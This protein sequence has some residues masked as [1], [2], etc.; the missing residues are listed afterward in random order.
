LG[1]LNFRP[2]LL[3]KYRGCSAPEWQIYEGEKIYSICH[4]IGKDFDTGDILEVKE[5]KVL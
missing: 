1:I 2:G 4:I 5:L 3:P